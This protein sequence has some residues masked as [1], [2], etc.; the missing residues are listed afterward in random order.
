M[1]STAVSRSMIDHVCQV[2][3]YPWPFI[4]PM[5]GLIPPAEDHHLRIHVIMAQ[6]YPRRPRLRPDCQSRLDPYLIHGSSVP[7]FARHT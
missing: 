3:D 2:S 4:Q 5:M 1:R 6:M 7:L